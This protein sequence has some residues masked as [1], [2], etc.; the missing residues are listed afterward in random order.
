M[1]ELIA[2]V[3]K[4]EGFESQVL[5]KAKSR[6][7]KPLNSLT[8][9]GYQQLARRFNGNVQE[10]NYSDSDQ[11]LLL[12]HAKALALLAVHM[13]ALVSE[14]AELEKAVSAKAGLEL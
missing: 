2:D 4:T 3:E 12:N 7:W 8:H 5:S 11:F 1:H 9:S 13:V 6:T 10:P 14:N